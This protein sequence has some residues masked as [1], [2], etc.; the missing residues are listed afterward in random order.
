MMPD[1][2]GILGLYYSTDAGVTWQ[3]ATL[4]D[5]TLVIQSAQI[6]MTAAGIAPA[7]I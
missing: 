5:G 7:R 4:E 3:L 1:Q 2:Q 6:A